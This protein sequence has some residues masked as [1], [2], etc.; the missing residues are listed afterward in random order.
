MQRLPFALKR[1]FLL[2]RDLVIDRDRPDLDRLARTRDPEAFV[3]RVLPHAAR[4]FAACIL[5]LPA[6]LARTAAAAYLY[7]RT[8]DTYEDLSP[9]AATRETAL[10]G[11][12]DRFEHLEAGRALPPPARLETSL[13][14][15]ARDRVHVLLVEQ[16]ERVDRFF[17]ALDASHR[18]LVLD[19]VRTMAEEMLW[20][21]RTL[22]AQGGVLADGEQLSRYCWGVLGTT[23]AFASRLFR[24]HGEG[25][26]TLT[27]QMKA[28]AAA[29][30]EFLQL[31]NVTRDLEKD[32]ARGV[33]YDPELAPHIGR[34]DSDA[35]LEEAVR[36]VRA[37]LLERA[38]GR[39]PEYLLLARGFR[40]RRLS[41][42]R[43]SAVL[44]LRFTER[45]YRGCAARA[46]YAVPRDGPSGFRLLLGA[47]P[48]FL[49]S[50]SADRALDRSAARLRALASP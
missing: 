48:A 41:L 19:L 3:W 40:Y 38:L 27:P 36:R 35:A 44:M 50:R 33:A 46:G 29:A 14:R 24:L 28:R 39:A 25:D 37:R 20:S 47:F 9:D 45:Y 42:N 49:S 18:E 1:P 22:A 10:R 17:L 8:L 31:A 30:G 26:A 43:A 2:L 23:I 6:P 4:T 11:F 7:C 5:M 16:G 13:A 12:A 21:S 34:K 32:L 15:D